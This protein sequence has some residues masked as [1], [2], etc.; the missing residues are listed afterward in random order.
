MADYHGFL[1]DYRERTAADAARLASIRA[2]IGRPP[3]HGRPLRVAAV[4]LTV[5]TLAAAAA[6]VLRTSP[7]PTGIPLATAGAVALSEH[8]QA[9]ID[10]EGA[11]RVDG[12][13]VTLVW[14]RGTVALE[15][16]PNQGV[17]LTVVTDEATVHVVG[18]AFT[19]TRDALGTTVAVS[20]GKVE[21]D[22]AFG[23]PAALGAGET[24]TCLPR[25]SAG[26]LGRVRALQD[27]GAAPAVVVAEVEDALTR[28]DAKGAVANELGALRVGALLSLDRPADALAAAEATLD[29]TP[30]ARDPELHRV[31]ARLHV[32]RGDCAAALPH[33]HALAAAAALGPDAA[34]LTRCSTEAP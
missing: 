24:R 7:T 21:T 3:P 28:P 1:R 31:A 27:G 19:V 34:L 10:G 11:A 4:V 6:L 9:D 15:V 33:L 16:E 30:G 12:E 26:A 5:T 13:V 14:R 17:D 23:G 25:T 18:T 2:G 20:R 32:T 29:G 22:C 8:V